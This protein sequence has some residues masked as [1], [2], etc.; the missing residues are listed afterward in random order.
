M[1]EKL[2]YD[3]DL[4]SLRS[5]NIFLTFHGR[6]LEGEEPFEVRIRNAIVTDIEN[7]CNELIL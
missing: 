1:L 7:K 6:P 5:R 4:F 3:R 2:G